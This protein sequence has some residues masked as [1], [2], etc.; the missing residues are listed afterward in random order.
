MYFTSYGPTGPMKWRD[1][2]GSMGVLPARDVHMPIGQ[3]DC[4]GPDDQGNAVFVLTINGVRLD[5][6]WLLVNREFV[7][8]Q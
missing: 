3:A 7:P 8:A 5:G 2:P 6:R 1:V 4:L